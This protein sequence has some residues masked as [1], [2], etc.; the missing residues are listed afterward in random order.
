[1]S[2]DADW[3]RISAMAGLDEEG[4]IL[5]PA[6]GTRISIVPSPFWK[7]TNYAAEIEKDGSMTTVRT[8]KVDR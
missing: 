8:V 2:R 7:T 1:M 5:P 3:K 4:N 6:P